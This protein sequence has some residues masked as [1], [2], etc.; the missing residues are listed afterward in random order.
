MLSFLSRRD[1]VY[2]N[3]KK[4][5]ES[6]LP[7]EKWWTI[8][9]VYTV[10]LKEKASQLCHSIQWFCTVFILSIGTPKTLYHT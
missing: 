10:P 9:Q 1:L 2:R 7:S 3:A 5:H 4:S 8:Y 6:C